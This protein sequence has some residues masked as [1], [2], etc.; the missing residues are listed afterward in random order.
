[1]TEKEF[2]EKL[3]AEGLNGNDYAFKALFNIDSQSGAI[4]FNNSPSFSSPDDS[5]GDNVYRF[6]VIVSDGNGGFT[7]QLTFITVTPSNT[8][9]F[10]AA[11]S[12]DVSIDE[13]WAV[14]TFVL[15]AIASDLD[16]PAQVLTYSLSG[17]DQGLFTIPN[18]PAGTYILKAW[19][20]DGG[21]RSQ[22][23]TVPDSGDVRAVFEF[24]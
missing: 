17:E 10:F 23:I 21:I 20:E 18:L 12:V 13:N 24:T 6:N 11:P 14:E 22:E 5:D 19:H 8:S 16:S 4:R 2:F 3:K 7:D 15:A 9:P 1:M